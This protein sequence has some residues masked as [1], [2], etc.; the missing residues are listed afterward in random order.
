MAAYLVG[1]RVLF[2]VIYLEPDG[3]E[4]TRIERH[5]VVMRADEGH[6]IMVDLDGEHLGESFALPPETSAFE[7]VNADDVYRLATTGETVSDVDFVAIWNVR[8]PAS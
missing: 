4:R 8:R 7:P 5:G 1:S 2:R 6:P 3:S